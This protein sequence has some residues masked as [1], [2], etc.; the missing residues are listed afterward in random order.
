MNG[1]GA[2]HNKQT[3]VISIK[4]LKDGLARLLPVSSAGPAS[5]SSALSICGVIN[6]LLDSTFKLSVI[7]HDRSRYARFV[8]VAP[9][10]TRFRR[11]PVVENCSS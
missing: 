8:S 4:D 10:A 9:A 1:T 3:M 7:G 5:G 2:D 6:G 11:A